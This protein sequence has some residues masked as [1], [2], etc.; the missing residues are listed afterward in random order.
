METINFEM[1]QDLDYLVTFWKNTKRLFSG[2]C[3]F[4]AAIITAELEKRNIPFQIVTWEYFFKSS[5]ISV[6]DIA[7]DEQLAHVGVRVGNIIIGGDF[8]MYGFSSRVY[9]NVSS[10]ELMNTYNTNKWNRIYDTKYNKSFEFQVKKLFEMFDY[11]PMT[12]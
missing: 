2:G 4:A 10:K 5:N 11:K 7:N 6:N 1:I 9:N 8:D 12:C 3:C